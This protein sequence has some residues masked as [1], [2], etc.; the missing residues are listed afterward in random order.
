[1]FKTENDPVSAQSLLVF[2]CFVYHTFDAKMKSFVL[3]YCF[4]CHLT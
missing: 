3:A 1:M 2:L 4:F